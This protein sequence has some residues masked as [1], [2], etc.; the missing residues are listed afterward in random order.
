MKHSTGFP[1]SNFCVVAI[2]VKGFSTSDRQTVGFQTVKFSIPNCQN[3][4]FQT[5]KI[6]LSKLSKFPFETVVFGKSTTIRRLPCKP[7]TKQI[8]SLEFLPLRNRQH[9]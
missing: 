4:P 6:F 7:C 5:V 9:P 3:F 8:Q 2:V 1:N